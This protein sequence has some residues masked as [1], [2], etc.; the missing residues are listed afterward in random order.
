MR[1]QTV[2]PSLAPWPSDGYGWRGRLNA[3]ARRASREE[4]GRLSCPRA[5]GSN[6]FKSS[7]GRGPHRWR[8]SVRPAP[9]RDAT[10]ASGSDAA[11]TAQQRRESRH[12]PGGSIERGRRG[13]RAPTPPRTAKPEAPNASN[14]QGT[15]QGAARTRATAQR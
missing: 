13:G 4:T 12:G 3:V 14:R 11:A 6:T 9:F 2:P 15:A 8:Q 1:W 5:Q 10:A 7:Q